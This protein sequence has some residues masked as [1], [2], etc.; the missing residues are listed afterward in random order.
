L[1]L[2]NEETQ[3]ENTMKNIIATIALV[4]F[5]STAQA[6]SNVECTNTDLAI[7]IAGG[8]GIAVVMGVS[9]V[10]GMALVGPG[11]AA[12][13]TVGWAGALSMPFLTKATAH[14]VGASLVFIA[15]VTSTA[16]YYG[17][18]VTRILMDK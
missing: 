16:G 1:P 17:A 15:P 14:M 9:T 13:S 7:G 4:L 3:M 8:V 6:K 2:Y 10:A 18:C 12:G 5:A 11:V